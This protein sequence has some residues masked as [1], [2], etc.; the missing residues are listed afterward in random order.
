ML[1]YR[2][3]KSKEIPLFLKYIPEYK[4][5]YIEPFLGG[6]SVFFYIEPKYAILNDLNSSL[7]SF[8]RGIRNNFNVVHQE[9]SL[10]EDIYTRNRTTFESLKKRHPNERVEDC[11]ELFY[12]NL[13]DMF[14]GL[15]PKQYSDATLYYFINKTAYS[16]MI[17]YNS[18][19]EFNVPYG[20]YK[21]F[22]TQMVTKEHS[23]LLNKAKLYDCDY[24][25]IFNMSQPED[26][27]FLDPPYDCIFSDYGNEKYKDGFDEECHR[28]LAEDFRNLSCKAM[29]VIG[30]TPLTAELYNGMI[31]DEYAK[32]YAVNIRNRFKAA[33][34]HIIVTNY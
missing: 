27:M 30:K 14:N 6:G 28:K 32:K 23:N 33:A 18:K 3:G 24:S 29:M 34:N 8:Y 21:N 12:Y 22:N 2:G 25:S 11:N 1:K 4:G 16:G 17:R 7:M 15:I 10:I 19:G 9:L 13:R 31:R 20:R 5:R 26:F